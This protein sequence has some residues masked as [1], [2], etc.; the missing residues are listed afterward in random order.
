LRIER[1][2]GDDTIGKSDLVYDMQMPVVC[3]CHDTR[4]IAVQWYT[5]GYEVPT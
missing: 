1:Q 5:F 4:S 3:L 2:P